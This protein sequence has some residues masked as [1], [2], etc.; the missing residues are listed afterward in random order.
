VVAG[1]HP[2]MDGAKQRIKVEGDKAGEKSGFYV[3]HLDGHP[4]G[5]F[6]NNRTG[7]ETRW[8]AKGYSFTAAQKAALK[9]QA[10]IQQQNRQAEQLALQQTVAN[11]LT[12]LLAVAP[13]ADA[14]HPDLKDK[15]VRPGGLKTV[16]QNIDDLPIQGILQIAQDGQQA[17]VLR[18]QHPDSIVLTTGDLLLPAQAIDEQIWSVQTI[19]ANGSKFF[20]AGSKKEHSFH[21]AGKDNQELAAVIHAVPAIVIAE[22]YATADTLSNALG[23][24]VVAAFDAGN[25]VKVAQDLHDQYPHKPIII[26]GDDDQHQEITSGKNPGKEK[27]LAAAKQVNGMV[28]FPTFAPDE[29]KKQQLSDFNDLAQQSVLGIDAVKRQVMPVISRAVQEARRQKTSHPIKPPQHQKKRAMA[30]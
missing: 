30:R 3:A 29:Q 12:Q 13:T 23:Y 24:P 17:K 15:Q 25:L 19:Q 14:D 2:L 11:A 8:R 10:A 1:K 4:A 26:A 6:K 16:P 21:V 28:V 22:G 5:Y 27:A 18:E 20:A 7:F 9:A